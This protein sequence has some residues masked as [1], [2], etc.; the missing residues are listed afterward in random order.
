MVPTWVKQNTRPCLNADVKAEPPVSGISAP[1][2]LSVTRPLEPSYI[3][4]AYEV[5][6]LPLRALLSTTPLSYGIPVGPRPKHH[7]Q[8]PNTIS[9]AKSPDVTKARRSGTPPSTWKPQKEKPAI[10]NGSD[11]GAACSSP[12]EA[13]NEPA[14]SIGI[15]AHAPL[16][17]FLGIV[18]GLSTAST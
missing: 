17:G 18:L 15:S 13:R 9:P 5:D 8:N 1:C 3:R 6:K 12:T 7:H 10:T 2:S 11:T 16:V 14:P 4:Q